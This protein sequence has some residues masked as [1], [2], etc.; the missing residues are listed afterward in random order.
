LKSTVRGTW[1]RHR[2]QRWPAAVHTRLNEMQHFER[3][4]EQECWS[5]RMRESE[6][7]RCSI[8]AVCKVPHLAL[9]HTRKVPSLLGG[10]QRSQPSH[11]FA[12]VRTH[13]AICCRATPGSKYL[14]RGSPVLAQPPRPQT[15]PFFS[16]SFRFERR[17]KSSKF[18]QATGTYCSPTLS[19]HTKQ[20][21]A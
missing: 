15:T 20:H 7:V 16:L 1:D 3:T 6:H 17:R 11:S 12:A 19:P 2:L 10:A 9:L 13:C 14:L 18:E 21:V 4:R 8:G 5:A